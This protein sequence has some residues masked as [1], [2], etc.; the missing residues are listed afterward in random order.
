MRKWFA[1]PFILA[2]IL[3][4][5]A[6]STLAKQSAE[7]LT[8][9][10]AYFPDDTLVYASI[11]TDAG[12][13]ETLDGLVGQVSANL[14]EMMPA[15]LTVED[16]L[17]LVTFG[18]L[19][20][21]YDAS[22]GAWLGNSVSIGV[23]SLN[24]GSTQELPPAMLA[25]EIRD[26]AAA[27]AFFSELFPTYQMTVNDDHTLYESGPGLDTIIVTD[28]FALVGLVGG[29][30]QNAYSGFSSTLSDSEE[31]QAGLEALP[32]DGY[33]I[34]VYA[35]A[36]LI[37]EETMD[38]VQQQLR[39]TSADVPGMGVLSGLMNRNA[40]GGTAV[41]GFT[42]LDGR[43]L[44]V[45][46]A[47]V[48]SDEE[49]AALADSPG[50]LEQNPISMDFAG[51]VPGEAHL[52][53]LDNAFGPDLL[54]IFDALNAVAPV[55]EEFIDAFANDPALLREMDDDMDPAMVQQFIDMLDLSGINVGGM[56]KNQLTMLVAGVTGLNLENEILSW[57]TG[58]YA[59]WMTLIPV[60]SDL[61]FSFDV[62][63]ATENTD[64]DAATHVISRIAEASD[65]YGVTYSDEELGGGRAIG[66][67]API[68]GP[69]SYALD[70]EILYATPELD[71]VLGTNDDVF[72]ASTRPG[73]EFALDPGSDSLLDNP[74][75]AYA[76]E[77]VFLDDTVLAWY[78]NTWA[79]ADTA[80][81]FVDM[82][83]EQTAQQVAFALR[84]VESLTLTGTVA[85]DNATVIRLTITIP[86]EV[87]PMTTGAEP[88][89][90][91]SAAGFPL[92]PEGA[93]ARYEALPQYVTDEGFPALGSP[94]AP[95]VVESYASFGCPHCAAFHEAN[96]SG[97]LEM[98]DSGQVA[99]VYIP[100]ETGFMGNTGAANLAAMCLADSG[101]FWAYHDALFSWQQYTDTFSNADL[102]AAA[103]ELGVDTDSL[104]ACIETEA[105]DVI[106]TATDRYQAA[107]VTGTPTLFVNGVRVEN[108]SLEGI[109]AAMGQQG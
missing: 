82:L 59:T 35:N 66:L 4:L 63:Y 103:A 23:L 2:L 64:P 100:M 87:P 44:A 43:T 74:R 96:T 94:D 39:S 10:A 21:S 88:D 18:A 84:Q 91:A 38:M 73:A 14:G 79:M 85:S 89:T 22:V 72:V 52:V 50:Y 42:I 86:E 92:I 60:E 9:M 37:N 109:E 55:L 12:F 36:R 1:L 30:V 40:T 20:S 106:A 90:T 68:R 97:I 8:G 83:G 19:G 70:P 62:G 61:N 17:D 69:L 93:L 48:L 6:G 13:I 67:V 28:E 26:R 107:G 15:Q 65:L 101:V 49:L 77:N 54:A 25:L 31:F 45:D 75:F 32:E 41:A 99:Y 71:L 34:L 51:Y 46:F 7:E 95:F 16:V 24:M 81:T 47:G 58:D 33:N 29:L 57:M 98:V 3:A 11:R 76:A 27:E 104:S 105:A 102:M 80:E 5:A 56:L 53:V 78:I 108:N